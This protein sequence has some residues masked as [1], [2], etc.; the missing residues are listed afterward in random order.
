MAQTGSM[1]KI[2]VTKL[3]INAL[4]FFIKY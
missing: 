3:I 1:T 2:I 4:Y